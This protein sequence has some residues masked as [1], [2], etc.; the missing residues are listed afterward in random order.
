[1]NYQDPNEAN[2]TYFYPD[3][4]YEGFE[5]R[6]GNW[7]YIEKLKVEI[8]K[9]APR[10]KPVLNDKSKDIFGREKDSKKNK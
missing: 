3:G 2:R 7:K 6:N 10:E 9:S 8:Q 4:T 5:F 1:M